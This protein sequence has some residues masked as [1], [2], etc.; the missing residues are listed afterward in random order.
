MG[1]G[2]S[3]HPTIFVSDVEHYILGKINEIKSLNPMCKTLHLAIGH[4]I[5][6]QPCPGHHLNPGLMLDYSML[7]YFN[8]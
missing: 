6:I 8:L 2:G 4:G 7:F 3:V 5:I 1:D